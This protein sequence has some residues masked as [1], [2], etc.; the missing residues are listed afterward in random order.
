[1]LSSLLRML[2]SIFNHGYRSSNPHGS[3]WFNHC[4]LLFPALH[5]HIHLPTVTDKKRSLWRSDMT[6]VTQLVMETAQKC[7]IPNCPKSKYLAS[8]PL[9]PMPVCSPSL[10]SDLPLHY[11]S[12]KP[13]TLL[14]E[15]H[16][17]RPHLSVI[18]CYQ[19]ARPMSQSLM[20]L[21]DSGYCVGGWR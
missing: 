5:F 20:Y 16:S 4:L 19:A 12:W 1:M 8:G 2:F 11:A 15:Q 21:C 17:S 18:K 10:S 9:F 3:A 14:S 13:D 6:K 7:W